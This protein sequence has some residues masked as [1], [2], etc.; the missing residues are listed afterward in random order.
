M[1]R[2]E[3]RCALTEGEQDVEAALDAGAHV[4][5]DCISYGGWSHG[6]EEE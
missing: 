5:E 2:P 1:P 4:C 3:P 6:T